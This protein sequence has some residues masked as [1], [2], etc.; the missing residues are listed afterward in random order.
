LDQN[1][2]ILI[3]RI[4]NSFKARIV[5]ETLQ[6]E[7]Y[8]LSASEIEELNGLEE[9][10]LKY[11]LID[12]YRKWKPQLIRKID[13]GFY[14]LTE[15]GKKLMNKYTSEV[16]HSKIKALATLRAQEKKL[17]VIFHSIARIAS[18]P[19]NQYSPL[20]AMLFSLAF[21]QRVINK[22]E[23]FEREVASKLFT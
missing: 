5:L 16:L 17:I 9:E 12:V 7:V 21:T 13:R 18:C 20:E 11:A 15:Y 10:A 6:R 2:P 23:P 3:K 1:L 19:L 4:Q 14:E 22:E 8:P